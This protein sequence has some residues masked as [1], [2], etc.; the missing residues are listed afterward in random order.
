MTT[1]ERLIEAYLI[2]KP[3]TIKQTE[4]M[5]NCFLEEERRELI[6]TWKN[7][8]ESEQVDDIE[9]AAENYLEL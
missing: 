8:Y 3:H 9:D 6:E 1:L 5:M 7:G 4:F 2:A